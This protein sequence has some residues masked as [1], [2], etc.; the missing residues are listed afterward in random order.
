[1]SSESPKVRDS[2]FYCFLSDYRA[3]IFGSVRLRLVFSED[4]VS[5]LGFYKPTEVSG[6][7]FKTWVS[8]SRRVSDFTIP[9]P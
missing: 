5:G 9:Y 7:H 4:T 8:A 6:S 1:M 2:R 3:R